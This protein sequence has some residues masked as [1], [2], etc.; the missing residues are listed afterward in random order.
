MNALAQ[1]LTV[2]VQKNVAAPAVQRKGYP[3]DFGM[4]EGLAAADPNDRRPSPRGRPQGVGS[5][6][7]VWIER[8]AAARRMERRQHG[9]GQMKDGLCAVPPRGFGQTPAPQIET[10]P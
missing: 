2:G 8:G 5:A 1:P 7:A 6:R 4:V 9:R 3:A 10:Q